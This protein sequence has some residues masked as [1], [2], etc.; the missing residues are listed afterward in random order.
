[1]GHT[2]TF[3]VRGAVFGALGAA[4]LIAPDIAR[5]VA[6]ANPSFA[7]ASV[8]KSGA[9]EGSFG[10]NGQRRISIDAAYCP[11]IQTPSRST[12]ATAC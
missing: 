7:A 2:K 11:S 8:L 4:A 12:A 9:P 5:G 1:M 6:V 3:L 10:G